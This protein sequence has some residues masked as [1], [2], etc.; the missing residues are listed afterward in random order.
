MPRAISAVEMEHLGVCAH[1]AVV[2]T[3][4]VG[5]AAPAPDRTRR[6]ASTASR[7]NGRK[8]SSPKTPRRFSATSRSRSPPAPP[9]PAPPTPRA[10][11]QDSLAAAAGSMQWSRLLRAASVVLAASALCSPM[12]MPR[13]LTAELVGPAWIRW[14]KDGI[15]FRIVC[16]E[17]NVILSPLDWGWTREAESLEFRHDPPVSDRFRGS[18]LED[19][20][21]RQSVV[22]WSQADNENNRSLCY[23]LLRIVF[24]REFDFTYVQLKWIAII[25]NDNTLDAGV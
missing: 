17:R 11:S 24:S 12:A 8:P 22:Y 9:T 1:G 15:R 25:H 5:Q 21:C 13:C 16:R 7:C 3:F 18:S 10:S 6:T 4:G 20:H 23:F 2:T 14:E 19:V